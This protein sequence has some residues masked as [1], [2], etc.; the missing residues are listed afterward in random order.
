M[1]GYVSGR[2]LLAFNPYT[3]IRAHVGLRATAAPASG[4]GWRDGATVGDRVTKRRFISTTRAPYITPL[5][6]AE[7][8]AHND[9]IKDDAPNVLVGQLVY[10]LAPGGS[11]GVADP[12]KTLTTT[13]KCRARRDITW[14]RLR[15]DT[16]CVRPCVREC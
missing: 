15:K 16:E 14:P 8:R 6:A 12:R 2:C 10:A 5:A 13:L 7:A 9:A 3:L 4:S 11:R 1:V